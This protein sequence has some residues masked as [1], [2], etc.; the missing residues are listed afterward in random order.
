MKTFSISALA[1]SLVTLAS[2]AH[3]VSDPW[4]DTLATFTGTPQ[5]ALDLLS[6][7]V[8]FDATKQTF[9]LQ[10]QAAG[11]IAG[12]P[13]VAYVFGFNTGA[14]TNSPFASLGLPGVS[15]DTTVQLRAN[16]TG[17][18]AG[19]PV[20]V[21]IV[22]DTISA[23]LDATRLPSKGLASDQFQWA[24]WSIDSSVSGLARNADFAPNANIAV[25][26]VPEPQSYAL[27]SA[28][29]LAI[30]ALARRRRA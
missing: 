7:S 16:G 20:A 2:S 11:A 22:G 3:A 10:A 1:L 24:V 15:F 8:T 6:A 30:G 13:N 21:S 14:A 9:T 28:G 26:A 17:V 5:A 18:L 23:T 12:A 25:T 19:Q 27:M 4:G 29:L